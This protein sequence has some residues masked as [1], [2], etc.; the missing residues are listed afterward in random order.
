MIAHTAKRRAL[1]AALSVALAPAALAAQ[2]PAQSSH[3][4][5]A[6]ASRGPSRDAQVEAMRRLDYMVG[7]W[8]GT[9]WIEQRGG[10]R[11][12]FR[13]TE[14]VQR[15]LDGV[16]LL[17]EGN[18]LGRPTAAAEEVPVHTTL[19]VISYDER[20]K[21]Y[22]FNTWLAT[23]SSGEHELRLRDD[24]WQWTLEYPG[25]SV[26]YT[27]TLTA[28]GEWLEIGERTTDGGRTWRQFFEMRLRK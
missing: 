5:P 22:R 23:G 19:A 11:L 9:G 3:P 26:R 7:E 14:R 27:F 1:V 6:P 17:V 16:A 28:A 18:F 20:A 12:A 25:T 4:A 24:G 8:T 2:T 15:K 21:R 13:G 10:A